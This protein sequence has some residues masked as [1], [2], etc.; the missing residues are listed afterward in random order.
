MTAKTAEILKPFGDYFT[1]GPNKRVIALLEEALEEAKK[2]EIVGVAMAKILPN[3]EV[4]TAADEGNRGFAEI[5][6]SV[7]VLQH[8]LI[9]KWKTYD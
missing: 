4:A 3:G 6:G 8:D 9:V 7:A 2:G 5:C 1:L